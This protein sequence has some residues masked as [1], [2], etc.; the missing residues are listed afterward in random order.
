MTSPAVPAAAA[1]PKVA[2][3][4]VPAAGTDTAVA[5][6]CTWCEEG[7]AKEQS[8]DTAG[9]A[10]ARA[11]QAAAVVVLPVLPCPVCAALPPAELPPAVSD[12]AVAF[13]LLA[14]WPVSPPV[15]AVNLDRFTQEMTAC[16]HGAEAAIIMQQ[17]GH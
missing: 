8:Q 9:V 11:G 1:G 16:K 5:R 12:A 2:S 17:K 15:P 7:E 6:S 13:W 14:G 10:P 3:P 4:A